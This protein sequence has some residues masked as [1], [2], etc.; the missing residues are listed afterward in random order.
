[1][2][3]QIMET[4]NCDRQTAEY[5]ELLNDDIKDIMRRKNNG[6]RKKL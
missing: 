2:I 3:E 1:M 6:K 4:F 5:I